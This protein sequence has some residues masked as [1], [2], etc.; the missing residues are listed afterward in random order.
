MTMEVQMQINLLHHLEPGYGQY[1]DRGKSTIPM[2]TG[3]ISLRV[4][5]A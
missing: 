1:L 5:A 3:R 4:A 2:Y